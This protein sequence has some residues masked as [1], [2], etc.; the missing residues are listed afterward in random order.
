MK[1]NP[2]ITIGIAAYNDRR[3]P[4]TRNY[5][6]GVDRPFMIGWRQPACLPAACV[7]GAMDRIGRTAKKTGSATA[8]LSFPYYNN[9]SAIL[10]CPISFI[11]VLAVFFLISQYFRGASYF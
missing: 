1:E 3:W 4:K 7:P 10:P 5:P 8:G 11:L 2:D 9:I 6:K